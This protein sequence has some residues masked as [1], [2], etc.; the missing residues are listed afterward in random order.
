M[1]ADPEGPDLILCQITSQNV[2]DPYAVPLVS[3]DMTDGSLRKPS[4]IR[5]NRI[6][7]ADQDI[8]LYRVGAVSPAKLEQVVSA[9]VAL[10]RA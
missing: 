6:F 8:I 7:T 5:P 2:R 3:S 10:L 4:N 1:L 9:A